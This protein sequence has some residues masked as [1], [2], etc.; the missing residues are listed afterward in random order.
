MRR[1]YNICKFLSVTILLTGILFLS[2]SGK[3]W[4]EPQ[5]P[6]YFTISI[7]A[8]AL[9]KT[10]Q[11]VLPLEVD[12][13]H[14]SLRGKLQI[15][16]IDNIS[17]NN[18]SIS[19]S[20]IVSG[21]DISINTLIGGQPFKMKLGQLNMPVSSEFHFHFDQ[22]KKQ[23]FVTPSFRQTQNASSTG[24][25]SS[26]DL[27]PVLSDIIAKEYNLDINRFLSF[28]PIINGQS[29]SV[30]LEPVDIKTEEGLLIIKLRPVG[31]TKSSTIISIKEN[32]HE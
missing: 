12:P 1:Q 2:K 5:S 18:K 16:S 32:N 10:V 26:N 25:N 11:S 30:H 29:R 9:L 8:P 15:N 31:E 17:I 3:V 21:K 13:N 24:N 27:L 20:G 28:R 19:L 22:N 14:S 23:L 4:A 7:P 6:D